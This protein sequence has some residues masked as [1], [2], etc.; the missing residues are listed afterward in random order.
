[1]GALAIKALPAKR[2]R[3]DP[4]GICAMRIN[5]QIHIVDTNDF[6]FNGYQEAVV[7]SWDGVIRICAA[8]NYDG[9]MFAGQRSG[10]RRVPANHGPGISD[11]TEGCLILGRPL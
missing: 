3:A 6:V 7:M 9:H 10:M 4:E 8:R 5:G 1:M 2:E 11:V